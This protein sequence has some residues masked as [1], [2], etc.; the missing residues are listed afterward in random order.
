MACVGLTGARAQSVERPPAQVRSAH[1]AATRATPHRAE[2]SHAE[3]PHTPRA[4]VYLLRGL[5]NVFSLGMDTLGE[6]LSKRGV[7]T[8]VSNY[9]DWCALAEQAAA[10]YKAGTENPIILIGH[11]LG[12][13]AVMDMAAAL[14]RRDVPVAL[15]IPFDGTKTLYAPANVARVVNLTQRNY[16]YARRGAGFHG[17]L[18]NVDV[19]F[20][21][22][23][24]HINIDKAA[25]T[26]NRAISE[27]MAVVGHPS[28]PPKGEGA[29]VA[30]KPTSAEPTSS[31]SMPDEGAKASP[32][33][34]TA[35][36]TIVAPEAAPAARP[37]PAPVSPRSEAAPPSAQ[38]TSTGS[39]S[40]VPAPTPQPAPVARPA[41]PAAHSI[42]N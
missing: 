6:E 38:D 37:S 32:S 35:A 40:V 20:D 36:P 41:K 11:S 30:A 27:V 14:G 29:P 42:E 23:I 4:H 22:N 28:A 19:S 33:P 18:A 10:R 5:F 31:T 3:Q 8:S 13:D 25:R 2:K 1:H 39:V 9:A 26:H 16:A 34:A 17:S 15:V 7:Q 21:A 24:D 12:A